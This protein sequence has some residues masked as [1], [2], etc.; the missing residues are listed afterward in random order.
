MEGHLNCSLCCSARSCL[1]RHRSW[2]RSGHSAVGWASLVLRVREKRHLS[3]AV[4]A[5]RCSLHSFSFTDLTAGSCRIVGPCGLLLRLLSSTRA[6]SSVVGAGSGVA[7]S[8]A[9]LKIWRSPTSA[10]LLPGNDC[11]RQSSSWWSSSL[12]KRL[13]RCR[14]CCSWTSLPCSRVWR[15]QVVS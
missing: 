5:R 6:L 15:L 4:L 14:I 1:A 3:A 7:N 2:V 8:S 11:A 12:A 9:S 13:H 10:T